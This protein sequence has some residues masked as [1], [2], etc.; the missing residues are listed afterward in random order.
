MLDD[1]PYM[2]RESAVPQWSPTTALLVINVAVFLVQVTSSP[3][4]VNKYFAVSK[5]GLLD[6]YV[7]QLLTFQFLHGG[8]PHL[9][10]NLLGLYF[11][12]RPVEERMGRVPFLKLYLV[13]GMIGGLCQAG[14]GFIMPQVF[15]GPVVGAS[16][17]LCGLIAAFALLEPNATILLFFILPIRAKYFLPLSIIVS[18]VSLADSIWDARQNPVHAA[19][20]GIAHAAHLGGTLAGLAFLRWG[21]QVEMMLR[22]GRSKRSLFRPR[23]L[24]KVHSPKSVPWQES[25]A[26]APQDLPPAEFISREVDPI[27][28]KISAQGI[29]SLTPKER[30]ILEAAR[31]RMGKR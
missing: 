14:L 5:D 16:A 1:R 19:Q 3:A 18:V 24:I 12:G 31:A 15:G 10:F 4:T 23:E 21:A 25:G 17:G 20:P 8:V 26:E 9:V 27:L 7:W 30:R 22:R 2:R 28:D 6:G 13:S 29:H 11:F